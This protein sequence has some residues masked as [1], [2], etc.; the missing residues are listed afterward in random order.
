M[1]V[2][3]NNLHTSANASMRTH[4]SGRIILPLHEIILCSYK[5]VTIL[6]KH[7]HVLL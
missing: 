7:F 6:L 5:T 4:I 2:V 1:V 3:C